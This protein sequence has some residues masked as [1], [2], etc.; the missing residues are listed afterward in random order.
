MP[1]IAMSNPKGGAGKSTL[2]LMLATYLADNGATVSVVDADPVRQS[3]AF[4]KNQGKTRSTVRVVSALREN[5]I[6]DLIDSLDDQFIFIDL[7]GTTSVMV[8]RSIAIADFV[9]IPVQ[10][11]PEDVRA[12]KIAMRAV[13][14]EEKVVRRSNP[15]KRIPFKVLMTRTP[16]PGAPI[17]SL[18]RDLE[19]EI[20]EAN[21]P[22]FR[23]RFAE[24]PVFKSVFLEGL[25]L[26]E[27]DALGAKYGKQTLALAYQNVHE[28]VMELITYLEGKEYEPVEEAFDDDTEEVEEVAE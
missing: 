8:S 24:R 20:A 19:K 21:L 2:T 26:R 16:A 9:V 10:A 28:I 15:D 1:V 25:T 14:D 6:M 4:W 7:E 23:T 3:I 5:E 12:A 17:N 18:Q 22:I 11:S 13:R 27:I